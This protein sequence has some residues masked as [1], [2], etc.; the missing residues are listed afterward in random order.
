MKKNKIFVVGLGFVGL[1]TAIGFAKK[2]LNV[3]G[4]EKDKIKLK[5]LNKNK[6]YFFEKNLN[7][8][9]FLVKKSK[10]ISFTDRFIPHSDLNVVFLCL[11]T[12][13][14][15]NGNYNLSDIKH[16]I[17]SPIILSYSLGTSSPLF[18]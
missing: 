2:G 18:L 12:P 8:N 7:K 15:K 4:V 14:N 1:T 5:L 16:S 10:N 9:L 11:G 6:I 13:A 17:G 3:V